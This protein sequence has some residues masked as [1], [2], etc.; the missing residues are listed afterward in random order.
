MTLKNISFK[1]ILRNLKTFFSNPANIILVVF[2]VILSIAVIYPLIILAFDAFTIHSLREAKEINE[3]LETTLK[4]GDLTFGHWLLLMFNSEVEGFSQ[5]NFWDPLWK[6]VLMSLIA[7]LVAVLG[8][9]VIAWFITRSNMPCKKFISTV[10][11]FPY[12]M[13]SWSIAMFWEN[14]F[15]NSQI[16]SCYNEVGL[17]ESMTGICVPESLLYGFWPTAFVLGIHYMPFAYILIGGILRN[18]DANLE[19]AATILKAS[20]FKILRRITLPIV[21]PALI[22][23]VLLVFASSISS[24]TV[25]HFLNANGS[26]NSISIT[27]RSMLTTGQKGKGYVIAVIL[28]VFSMLIL[29]INNW[30]T[31]SRRNFTTVSGKSGQISK[32]N[33][34]KFKW[35]ITALLIA[36]VGFFAVFPLVTFVLESLCAKSGDLSTLTLKYW[37][38]TEDLDVRITSQLQ[39]SQGVLHNFTIWNA[40]G[41]SI[42][43]STVVALFAGTFGIL[44]GYAV[45]KNR[46]GKLANFVSSLAFLPYLI[47]ALSFGAV[48][49]A[50]ITMPQFNWL[51]VANTNNQWS[52]IAICIIAGSIKFLPFASRSGTNA[53]LQLSGEIEEAAIITGCPWGKRMTKILF[54]IQKSSFISGYLLPFISCMRELTLFTLLTDNFSLIT[55][56]LQFYDTYGLG[57]ISNA[58]NLLIVVFVIGANLLVNALTGASIDKGIG[59]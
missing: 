1:R 22:S 51:N 56:T 52:A 54:P 35:P 49:F 44:I 27:M 31:K 30:F 38:T 57:Q 26:F 55:N 19:E 3:V 43:V 58:I 42:L 9:G 50:L 5:T 13:P 2:A 7:C 8:G 33:L 41:R 18:M 14:F 59:G 11:V 20:R 6:S 34:G 48:F 17:L 40:F 53:M 4:K 25:P 23:T 29:T 24:Y 39:S 12:I 36:F 28:L 32:A 16:T 15:K 21:A 47:P 46:R 45:S 10:F 37:T